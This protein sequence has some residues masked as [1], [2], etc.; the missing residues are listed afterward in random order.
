MNDDR[1]REQIKQ[2]FGQAKTEG[3]YLQADRA[4]QLFDQ[5]MSIEPPPVEDQAWTVALIKVVSAMKGRS[6]EVL[7]EVIK[8]VKQR[9]DDEAVKEFLPLLFFQIGRAYEK[10]RASTNK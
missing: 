3:F 7:R 10:Y 5:A 6:L 8:D 2:M 9:E 4:L 1:F